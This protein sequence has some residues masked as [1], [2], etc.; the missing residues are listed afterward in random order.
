MAAAALK[1]ELER[2][3]AATA[4]RVEVDAGPVRNLNCPT[5]G[6]RARLGRRS[7]TGGGRQRAYAGEWPTLAGT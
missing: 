5:E 2:L 6:R 3:R 4:A 7:C 1:S